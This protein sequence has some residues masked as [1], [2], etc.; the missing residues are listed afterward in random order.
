MINELAEILLRYLDIIFLS[1]TVILFSLFAAM[2]YLATR[3]SLHY[4]NKNS[5]GDVSRIMASPIAP[6]ITIIAPAH[7]EG[8]TIVENVR[9]LLSLQYTNYQVMVV[10]D[11]SKDDTLEKV[12]AAYDMEKVGWEIDPDWPCKKVRGIYKSRQRSFGKLMV[13]DKENGGKSD[14]LN[15]GMHLSRSPYVGC[16]DVDCLLLP[17]SLLHVVKSFYQRSQ[18]R[19]IA[20]GGVIRVANSCVISGGKLEEIRLP[21]NWLARFQL[22]EYTRSFLLGRMAWGRIDSLLIISGAFGFFDREIALAVGGYSTDT[23]G[24]DME[25][26]FKMRRYMHDRKIPYTVEYIPDP[27]CWTEV[28]EDLKIFKNQ[29]DRW[30]RGNLETLY[31]HKDMFLNPKYGRLGMLSY[32]YWFFYEWLAPILEFVGFFSV[33]LFWYLGIINW[34]FFV[35]IT[36]MVYCFATM[37]SFYAVLW[38]VWSYNQYRKIK[39]IL[40]LLFCG[41]I[42]PLVFHPIVVWSAIRGNYK[43]LFKIQAGWGSQV[44]KG[45]AKA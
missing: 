29:R 25:I 42:E 19:V 34:D 26:V 17:E 14:A 23:V 7:N 3:S 8:M 24:E 20:V 22:L 37:F 12:I 9:S 10:N 44:R 36:L 35:A 30:A 28:P 1:F 5:I 27:L 15:A 39:D 43:K 4:R 21:K 31:K 18:K 40:I 13:V 32:P 33:L 16:I 41:M 2:G 6:E 45:F 11:G 38:E